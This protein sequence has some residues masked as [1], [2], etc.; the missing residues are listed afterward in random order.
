MVYI[1]CFQ[2]IIPLK[3]KKKTTKIFFTFFI[4]QCEFYL[5][6]KYTQYKR[7]LYPA[8]FLLSCVFCDLHSFMKGLN[9]PQFIFLLYRSHITC[10][11]KVTDRICLQMPTKCVNNQLTTF[12]EHLSYLF[13]LF[14][15]LSLG[16]VSFSHCHYFLYQTFTEYKDTQLCCNRTPSSVMTHASVSIVKRPGHLET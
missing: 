10:V 16:T 3:G 8:I 2:Q 9:V 5:K 11:Q 7:I 4:I 12:L 6:N 14:I 15:F 1:Y 13:I